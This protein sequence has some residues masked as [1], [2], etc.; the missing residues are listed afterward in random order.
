M[1]QPAGHIISDADRAEWDAAVM[2]YR[3]KHGDG[4]SN[5]DDENEWF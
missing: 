2:D 4:D 1:V 5:E 3:A